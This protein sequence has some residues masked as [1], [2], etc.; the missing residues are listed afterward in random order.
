[1]DL[2]ILSLAGER[3]GGEQVEICFSVSSTGT[4]DTRHWTPDKGQK[5]LETEHWTLD[6]GHQKLDTRNR[7]TEHRIPDTG[8]WTLTRGWR[9]LHIL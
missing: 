4:L 8:H 2:S 6:A 9:A 3:A 7:K 1:M 5:T